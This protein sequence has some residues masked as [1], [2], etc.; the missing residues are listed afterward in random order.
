MRPPVSYTEP[1]K[2]QQLRDRGLPFR[3]SDFEEDHF[4]PLELGGS[5][6]S[7]HNLWPMPYRSVPGAHEK[8]KVETGLRSKV[9][10]G[11]M[12]L[13]AAQARITSDWVVE[14]M[15]EGQP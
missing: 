12:T 7:I 15:A 10:A 4:I 9:C 6:T 13:A 5:P 3:L 1:L 11:K 2:K 14:W 8:D